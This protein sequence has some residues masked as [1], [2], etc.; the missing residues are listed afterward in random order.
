MSWQNEPRITV[1]DRDATRVLSVDGDLIRDMP[2][3]WRQNVIEQFDKAQH[4]ARVV[5]DVVNVT[6]LGSWGEKRIKSLARAV[7]GGGGRV[8][9]VT[10]PSRSA[11]YAGLRVELRDVIPPA[12]VVEE[13]GAALRKLEEAS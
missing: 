13:L 2:A 1:E 6:R 9:V 12:H 3:K 10:D 7:V 11:M 8:V 5:V 4:D